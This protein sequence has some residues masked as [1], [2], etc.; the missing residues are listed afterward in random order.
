MLNELFNVFGPT[1]SGYRKEAYL[2]LDD[3]W[4]AAPLN[5]MSDL[6]MWR[7]FLR[8]E[9]IKCGTRSSFTC[10][11]IGGSYYKKKTIEEREAINQDW[12]KIVSDVDA[13]DKLM[14]SLFE[15]AYLSKKRKDRFKLILNLL[16]CVSFAKK[17]D[18][19]LKPMPGLS[20]NVFLPRRKGDWFKLEQ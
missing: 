7:K 12:W 2:K 20:K 11:H 14:L 4:T 10:L 18:N 5:I 9:E 3:G 15:L 19:W 6:H 13:M 8:H 17:S 16:K 1:A